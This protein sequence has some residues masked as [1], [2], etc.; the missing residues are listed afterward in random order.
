MQ[1]QQVLK[2]L[3]ID[4]MFDTKK[5]VTGCM[6]FRGQNKLFDYNLFNGKVVNAIIP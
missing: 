3:R 2:A 5:N 4:A 6:Y 1:S